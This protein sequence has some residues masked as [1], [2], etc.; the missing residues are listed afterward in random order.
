[1]QTILLYNQS[2]A[3]FPCD[4]AQN[5]LDDNVELSF[6]LIVSWSNK[7]DTTIRNQ[8]VNF[9]E[10][11]ISLIGVIYS[12]GMTSLI[13]EHFHGWNVRVAIAQKDHPIKGDWSLVLRHLVI[14]GVV[15]PVIVDPLVDPEQVLGFGCVVYAYARPS[16][17]IVNKYEFR[18]EH[19]T[20]G[21]S[22]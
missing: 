20:E 3:H 8:P 18:G 17:D 1:M 19:L 10:V 11:A 7:L 16:R 15:V 9:G 5:T 14:D 6:L 4:A 13:S 21:V 22:D 2:V 12:N